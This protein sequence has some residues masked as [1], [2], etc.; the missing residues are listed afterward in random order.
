MRSE[1]MSRPA[2]QTYG[3]GRA[4][5]VGEAS[6]RCGGVRAGGTRNEG[7]AR[8]DENAHGEGDS[9][10]VRDGEGWEGAGGNKC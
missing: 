5:A 8:G 2:V 6:E 3:G 10:N 7:R 1:A 9:R 4:H